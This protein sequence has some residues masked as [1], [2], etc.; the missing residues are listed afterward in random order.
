[1]TASRVLRELLFLAV[2]GF[3]LW[4]YAVMGVLFI[5]FY[6]PVG[7][8]ALPIWILESIV[9]RRPL[10]EKLSEYLS[11]LR[12]WVTLKSLRRHLKEAREVIIGGGQS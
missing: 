4:V 11:W 10:S 2:A 7:L 5:V 12:D 8:I 6:V 9:K 3:L 1:M